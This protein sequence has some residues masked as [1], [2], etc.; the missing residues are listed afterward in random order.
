MDCVWSH[1]RVDNSEVACERAAPHAPGH[2]P[3]RF[4]MTQRD[5]GRE[6]CH[7]RPE[8]FEREVDLTRIAAAIAEPGKVLVVEGE[9]GIGKSALLAAAAVLA[10]EA[11]A[12]VLTARGGVLERDFGHGVARQLFEAPLRAASAPERQRWLAGAAGLAAPALGLDTDGDAERL[13]DPAFAAQHGLYWLAAN[14]ARERPLVLVV[15]DLH[16]VDVT[17]LRWLVYLARRLE[18]LAIVLFVGWRVG[19]PDAPQ[20]LLDALDGERLMPRAL[21]VATSA[22]LIADE[23]GRDCDS[24]TAQACHAATHGNP[25]LLSQL[26]QALDSNIELPL[27]S[28]RIAAIGARAVA[29]HVRARLSALPPPTGA[30]AAAAAVLDGDVAPRQL[31]ALTG[32]TLSEVREACDRLVRA[33]LLTGH[34]TFEFAHPL[35]RAAVYD[36]LDPAGRAAAHRTAAD[37]L[38][39]EGLIDRAAV[40][41]VVAERAGDAVLV[42]RLTDA[43]E[44]AA[45]RGAVEEAVV[46]LRR[47]LQEPPP[48]AERYAILLALSHA[49]W[50]ARDEAGIEHARIAL[51]LA[52][53][54]RQYEAA[55]IRVA[56]L[57]SAAGRQREAVDVLAS[58]SD[59]VRDTAPEGALRLEVE[60]LSWLFMLPTAP[61][62]TLQT[63]LALVAQIEPDSLSAR[64]L[65]GT[66][67]LGAAV[68]GAVP[69]AAAADMALGAL[70]DRRML[71]DLNV[72]APFH[73]AVKALGF[74]ER[75]D[76]YG[77]WVELRREFASRSGSRIEPAILA[78]HRA[79]IAWLRGDVNGAMHEARESLDDTETRGYAFYVPFA[80]AQLVAT[81]VEQDKL[82]EAGDVLARRGLAEGVTFGWGLLVPARISLSLATGNVDR[83]VQQLAAAPPEST[84]RPLQM[85]PSEVLVAIATGAPDEARERARAMLDAAQLF[86][87]PAAIG[88]AQRLLGLATG[89]EHGIELLR[90]AVESL[91]S[92]AYRLELARAWVDYGAALRRRKQRAAAR[93]PLRNGLDLAQRCGAIV[94]AQRASDELRASGAR[95]RR[96]MLTGVEALTPSELRVARLAAQGRSNPQVAQ[97]L[98]VTRATVET[99]LHAV[100]RKLDLSSRDQLADA[101]AA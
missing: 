81:L 97:S 52:E 13:D 9:A 84:S 5:R 58:A 26:A 23:L 7:V 68:S 90:R 73:W 82:D 38:D 18:G 95:P 66:M 37:V 91:Q 59:T 88:V 34:E 76:D 72:T 63:A 89:G 2:A 83:A 57:L 92:T 79:H 100:Y 32:L 50:L 87:A 24:S 69:A 42:A 33:R 31:A 98:Y 28:Q 85:A 67:A 19:E 25:L 78:S 40:H 96:L 41:L 35:V 17:S 101:L 75:L 55:A 77:H 51:A 65:A 1:R 22:R 71:E 44:R 15:D 12:L 99:H 36:A 39:S 16:W 86:G 10:R 74:C 70:A 61:P 47:A 49:E 62:D 6:L 80:A 43:A 14:I 45:T 8:L 11:G 54:P 4:L 30:V 64:M 60:R 29:P 27:D 93:Q 53:G 21:S 20:G 48:P 46:L 3:A 56:R 94:L